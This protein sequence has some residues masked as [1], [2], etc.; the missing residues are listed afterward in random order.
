ML[1]LWNIRCRWMVVAILASLLLASSS[2][3]TSSD[4]PLTG[5][6]VYP[7][8]SN[9]ST[10]PRST[11]C[12]KGMQHDFYIV[13]G[14]KIDAVTSWYTRHLG[15]FHKYHAVTDGRSQDTFFSPDGTREVTITGSK[16]GSEVYSISYGRF[17][18]GLSSREMS[19]FNQAKSTCN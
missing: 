13:M 7:G 8:I 6:P 16:A 3:A 5:L 18:F 2:E 19:S 15:G 11:F 17:D 10:L 12:G 4:D 1:N 9:P 14:N